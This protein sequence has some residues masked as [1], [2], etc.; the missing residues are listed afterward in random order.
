MGL[1]GNIEEYEKV[2]QTVVR[3]SINSWFSGGSLHYKKSLSVLKRKS[4]GYEILEDECSNIGATEVVLKIINFNQVEVG[5]YE[6]VAFNISRD[7]ESGCVD[8]WDLKLI[9]YEDNT[10]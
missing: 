6:L 7:R 10:K 2:C 3:V 8:D 4:F 9:P 1:L 5:L